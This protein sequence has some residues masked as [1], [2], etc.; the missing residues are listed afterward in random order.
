MGTA[1]NKNFK[2]YDNTLPPDGWKGLSLCAWM[3]LSWFAN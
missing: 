2:R 1:L 3:G